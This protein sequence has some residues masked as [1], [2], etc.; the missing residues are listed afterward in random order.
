MNN[1]KEIFKPIVGYEGIYE[2]SNYGRV[3]SLGRTIVHNGVWGKKK[4]KNIKEKILSKCLDQDG[5]PRVVLC[6]KGKEKTY[7]IHTL[8]WKAFGDKTTPQNNVI[9]DHK[10]EN[11]INS[12]IDNLQSLSQRLNVVKS[13]KHRKPERKIGTC[14]LPKR[15]KWLAQIY[16]NGFNKHLGYFNTEEEAS[17]KYQEELKK[18]TEAKC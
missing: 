5:Y 7:F 15:N 13:I 1:I 14:F 16:Y 10:D 6:T 9:I 3:K 11:K 4:Q 18:L 8:V 2:I 12:R 17:N